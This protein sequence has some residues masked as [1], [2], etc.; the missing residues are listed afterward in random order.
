[1]L[2]SAATPEAAPMLRTAAPTL[3][4]VDLANTLFRLQD[5]SCWIVG[6]RRQCRDAGGGAMLWHSACS[7][8]T[9]LSPGDVLV[10]FALAVVE[11]L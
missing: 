1:M 9:S 4:L 8:V 6:S 10:P 11:A 3:Q 7:M 5:R 2:R